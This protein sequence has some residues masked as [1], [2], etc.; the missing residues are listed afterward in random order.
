[1]KLL[2]FFSCIS[3]PFRLAVVKVFKVENIKLFNSVGFSGFWAGPPARKTS[4]CAFP[5]AG[6]SGESR[7]WLRLPKLST[8]LLLKAEGERAKNPKGQGV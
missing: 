2:F 8:Q 1:M 4:T 7:P 3:T 6:N 5:K